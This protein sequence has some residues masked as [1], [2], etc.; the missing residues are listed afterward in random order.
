MLCGETFNFENFMNFVKLLK[1]FN[2]CYITLQ[3]GDMKGILGH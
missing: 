2:E 3:S 1:C